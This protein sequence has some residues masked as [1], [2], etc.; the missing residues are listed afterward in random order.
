MARVDNLERMKAQRDKNTADIENIKS[1]LN[2]QVA[3]MNDFYNQINKDPIFDLKR[4]KR[5]TIPDEEQI[6]ADLAELKRLPTCYV[7]GFPEPKVTWSKSIGSLPDNRSVVRD[8]QLTVLKAKKDDSG[9]Y[10]CKAENRFGSA[11]GSILVNVIDLPVFVV[12]P[13]KTF[14]VLGKKIV[15]LNCTAIGDPQPVISWRKDNGV[16][17]VGRYEVRD[18][19]LIIRNVKKAD[20]GVFV[21]TATSAGVSHSHVRSTLTVQHANDCDELYK[22]GVTRSDVYTVQPDK[23]PAFQVYCDMTTDGGGWTVFQRRQDGSVDFYR[24]WQQYKRGFGNLNGE[25]WL[26]NDYIH[27]LTARTASSLRVELEDWDGTRKYAKYGSF[28][29]GDESDKYRLR[30]GSYSGTAG[31]SLISNH[32]N[33]AFST[34]DRDNDNAGINCAAHFRNAWWYNRCQ[35]S[36]LNGKYPGNKISWNSITWYTFHK[37]FQSLKKSEMKMRTSGF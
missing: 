27:R 32:N 8:G 31:D 17:P 36:H 6:A 33:M 10:V 29:V 11:L 22:S 5:A 37:N 12:K 21:C 18:G 19:S 23:Q 16:L 7:T 24:N 3:R 2:A 26:G 25:F 9:I 1:M 14:P 13:P 15:V 20:S 34:K 28:S 4:K 35:A 30:V